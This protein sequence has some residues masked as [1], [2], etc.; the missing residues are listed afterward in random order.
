LLPDPEEILVAQLLCYM[1][2]VLKQFFALSA[3]DLAPHFQ[4]S[5]PLERFSVACFRSNA[6]TISFLFVSSTEPVI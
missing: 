6:S 4:K 3:E 1:G 5:Q 2:T